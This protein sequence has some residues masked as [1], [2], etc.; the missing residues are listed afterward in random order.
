MLLPNLGIPPHLPF[1]LGMRLG[2]SL[3]ACAVG[4]VV[5]TS[6]SPLSATSTSAL[7]ASALE[8]LRLIQER[9]HFQLSPELLTQLS[10]I[11]N[12]TAL[13]AAVTPSEGVRERQTRRRRRKAASGSALQPTRLHNA[14]PS[15][16]QTAAA[17]W[18]GTVRYYTSSATTSLHESVATG[19]YAE[20]HSGSSTG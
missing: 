2:V 15:L 3:L 18:S 14:A 19:A 10:A 9:G 13:S 20:H 12:Q 11:E 6:S 1:V 17:A 7:A 16:W 4:A 5:A 8:Q